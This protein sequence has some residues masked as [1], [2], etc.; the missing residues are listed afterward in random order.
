MPTCF[1]IALIRQVLPGFAC[2]GVVFFSKAPGKI[3]VSRL[4]NPLPVLVWGCGETWDREVAVCGPLPHMCL[5]RHLVAEAHGRDE[6]LRTPG[7]TQLKVGLASPLG[8]MGLTKATALPVNQCT[9]DKCA[10]HWEFFGSHGILKKE[11]NRLLR[12]YKKSKKYYS[13]SRKQDFKSISA[14]ADQIK[15]DFS[16]NMKNIKRS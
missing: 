6:N 11:G 4:K 5:E 16:M 1:L 10:H 15:K 2:D 3:Q 13:Y 9:G 8:H 7:Q 14:V 12:T